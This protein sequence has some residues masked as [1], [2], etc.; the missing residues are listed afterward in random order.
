MAEIRKGAVTM[1]GNPVDLVGP[2][3]KPGAKAPD[4]T[5]ATADGGLKTVSLA[6]TAGKARLFSV[7]PSLDTPV[8]NK[9]TRTLSQTLQELGD[10]VASY[11]ISMDL[12]FAMARFCGEANVDNM[13]NLSDLHNHSFGEHYGVLMQGPPVPLL[14]RAVFV[15]DP[16]NTITYV[17][18][19][20]EVGNEPDYDKAIAALKSA[21]GAS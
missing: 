11:T 14:S 4:V 20:P 16:N 21:A 15:V 8:C 10:S 7:V 5:C 9:Q 17:E 3:M 2:E 1:K 19:V 18:Y 6:D 12:P 13:T